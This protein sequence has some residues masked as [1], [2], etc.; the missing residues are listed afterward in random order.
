[1]D[2]RKKKKKGGRGCKIQNKEVDNV[3]TRFDSKV[4]G[5]SP[6]QQGSQKGKPGYGNE[7]NHVKAKEVYRGLERAFQT[8]AKDGQPTRT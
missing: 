8:H 5:G 7:E 4:R 1:V 3:Y 6:C 2:S